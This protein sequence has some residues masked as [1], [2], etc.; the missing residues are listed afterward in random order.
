MRPRFGE[1]FELRDTRREI[2][3]VEQFLISDWKQPG[4]G[5]PSVPLLQTG[6]PARSERQ[7]RPPSLRH[8][9]VISKNNV[10][11]LFLFF[12]IVGEDE[13]K[14]EIARASIV[15]INIGH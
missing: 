13:V 5:V 10:Y 7:R 8:I 15:A 6:T 9:I 11:V 4:G 3:G 1:Y 2:E 14:S 12:S